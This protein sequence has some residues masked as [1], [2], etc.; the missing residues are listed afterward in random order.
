MSTSFKQMRKNICKVY[1]HKINKWRCVWLS[2]A[3]AAHRNRLICTQNTAAW[4]AHS[5]QQLQPSELLTFGTAGE[6]LAL[7]PSL[8]SWTFYF[9]Q[10]SRNRRRVGSSKFESMLQNAPCRTKVRFV[11]LRGLGGQRSGF[12]SKILSQISGNHWMFC[13]CKK[14]K[15]LHTSAVSISIPMVFK[16]WGN[17]CFQLEV[18]RKMLVKR[19]VVQGSCF[20]S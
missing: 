4:L 8:H 14:T 3:R 13:A 11:S 6:Q 19:G 16:L 1:Y 12:S 9:L 2:L 7:D 5:L 18:N 17:L 15:L 10:Q 20:L